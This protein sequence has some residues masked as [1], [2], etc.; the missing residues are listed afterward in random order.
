METPIG[1]RS[2]LKSRAGSVSPW[3]VFF[4][5]PSKST[6]QKGQQNHET[7]R[8]K[9]CNLKNSKLIRLFISW[10]DKMKTENKINI[11]TV[12]PVPPNIMTSEWPIPVCLDITKPNDRIFK[13][14]QALKGSSLTQILQ[15]SL[16]AFIF[17][18]GET[19]GIVINADINLHCKMRK[20]GLSKSVS[21]MFHQPKGEI[22][23]SLKVAVRTW[24]VGRVVFLLGR[25]MLVL[26]SEDISYL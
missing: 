20:H 4:W 7:S 22:K 15:S 23:P 3:G 21:V 2:S 6:N 24:T 10:N 16:P 26:G 13:K 18:R 19:G 17:G 5:F 1:I 12:I 9:T 11:N 14:T 8:M 25:P